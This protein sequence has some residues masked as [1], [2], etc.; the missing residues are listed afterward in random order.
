MQSCRL[1]C[2]H[3]PGFLL[4]WLVLGLLFPACL[5]LYAAVPASVLLQRVPCSC[6][7]CLH[8][9]LSAQQ[10]H[11]F[12]GI[13][14]KHHR[15]C[16]SHPKAAYISQKC[17]MVKDCRRLVT[18]GKHATAPCWLRSAAISV[19]GL[20]AGLKGRM[21]IPASP[22]SDAAAASRL[23]LL[24]VVSTGAA[25]TSL[26]RFLPAASHQGLPIGIAHASSDA[27]RWK[28]RTCCQALMHSPLTGFMGQYDRAV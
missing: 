10:R 12:R 14:L 9:V 6:M 19:H 16:R 8:H 24:L 7:A 4:S 18:A 28:T 27:D 5:L 13:H 1:H 2:C 22:L 21:A 20:H 23:G 3:A 26:L 15:C 11:S 25:G 17:I